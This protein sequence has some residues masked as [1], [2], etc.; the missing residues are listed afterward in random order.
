MGGYIDNFTEFLFNENKRLS[1]KAAVVVISIIAIFLIDNILGFSYYYNT[2]KKIEQIQKL[3]TIIKDSSSDNTT[4]LFSIK[5]RSDLINR[6]NIIYKSRL[7][8]R[9]ITWANSEIQQNNI[10]PTIA[11]TKN[12]LTQ[13]TFWFNLTSGGL[14]YLFAIIMIPIMVFTDKDTSLIQRFS[15]GILVSALFWGLGWLLY[16]A[17]NFIPQISSTTWGW[18]YTI[19]IFVQVMSLIILVV[20][21]QKKK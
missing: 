12:P 19:N 16:W 20:I 10:L 21:G 4:K 1:I 6:E 14:Y 3:N 7:F 18:N 15:T 2:E 8:L 17:C 9:N 13:N 5:L 11:N